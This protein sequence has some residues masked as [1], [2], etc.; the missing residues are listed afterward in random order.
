MIRMN[1]D[2]DMD[3]KLIK[4]MIDNQE[5]SQTT[6]KFLINYLIDSIEKPTQEPIPEQTEA[7]PTPTIPQ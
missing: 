7:D 6:L 4:Y 3:L 5:L 1:K 2:K